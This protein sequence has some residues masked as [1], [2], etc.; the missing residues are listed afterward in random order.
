MTETSARH[1]ELSLHALQAELHMYYRAGGTGGAGGHFSILAE[2]EA[3]PDLSKD[4]VLLIAPQ[5]FR[6]STGSGYCTKQCNVR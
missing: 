3:K 6:P 2:L 4:L 1:L 5:I